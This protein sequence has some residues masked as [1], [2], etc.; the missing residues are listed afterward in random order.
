MLTGIE[1]PEIFIGLVSPVGVDTQEVSASAEKYFKENGYEVVHIKV[2]DSYRTLEKH[3]SPAFKLQNTPFYDRVK[4]YIAYGNQIRKSFDD[5]A[6]LA[7]AALS[8]IA[9]SRR[10][11]D[12]SGRRAGT[13]PRYE[14]RVYLI[15]QFKRREEVALMRQVYGDLFF[16]F[17]V[18]SRRDTRISYMSK[19]IA[20]ERQFGDERDPEELARGLLV[21]DEDE[22]H[23]PYGQRVASIFHQADLII[24]TESTAS[25]VADQFHR[26]GELLFGSN[27]IS[28]T[29]DEYG[30]YAAKVSALRTLDLSRQVGAAIFSNCGEILSLGSN[31]VPKAGG[32]TYWNDGTRYDARD[33]VLREDTNEIRKR[34]VAREMFS[35]VKQGPF[36]EEEFSSFMQRDDVKS[37]MMMDVIEYGRMVHAEMNAITDAARLGHAIK[38]ATLYCTTFPC[39]ICAKHIV[40]SGIER[41]VYLEPYP[42]SLAQDQHEDSINVDGKRRGRFAT[43][44]VVTFDHFSGIT[45]RR[46]REMFE[47]GKRK[48]ADGALVSYMDGKKRPIVRILNPSYIASESIYITAGFASLSR[49]S[50]AVA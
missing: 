28:P 19:R 50:T 29:L 38:G 24:N 37:S 46:Y 5:N 23:D 7:V 8:L 44:P 40:A 41:V 47:R 1:F 48:D 35:L 30:L 22:A 15:S 32:G 49:I 12:A 21:Q 11:K 14:K 13:A 39:H 26:F 9:Q 2:T 31:E 10:L 33:Y 20:A 45:P 6:I 16:Q 18:Y 43:Y 27:V 3:I 25:S 34:L 36:M 4:S 42:K 17:S